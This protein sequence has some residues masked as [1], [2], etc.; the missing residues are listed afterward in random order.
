MFKQQKRKLACGALMLLAGLVLA[1]C[2]KRQVQETKT[3]A[4]S[5]KGALLTVVLDL[6]GSCEQLMS[7]NGGQGYAFTMKLI[8]HYFRTRMGTDDRLLLVQLSANSTHPLLWEGTPLAL[9]KQFPTPQALRS[10]LLSRA[11]P[12]GSLVYT[13]VTRALEHSIARQS[14]QGAAG[15]NAVIVLSD[16]L[17]SQGDKAEARQMLDAV[18]RYSQGGG[19]VAFYYVDQTVATYLNQHLQ[20]LG[21][22]DYCVET[23]VVAMPPLPNLD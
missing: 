12:S 14:A 22:E 2:E 7:A 21:V 6:S 9:R 3:F 8:D 15:K 16:L 17:D 18:A 13:G 11:D 23:D 4:A 1:G 20:E 10:H 5:T 19:A